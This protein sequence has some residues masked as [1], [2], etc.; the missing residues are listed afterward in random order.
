MPETN[1]LGSPS[2]SFKAPSPWSVLAVT[3]LVQVLISGGALTPPVFAPEAAADMGVEPRL[4]GF[5]T[6]IVYLGAML[7]S[8]PTGSIVH[9]YGAM[10][11]SQVCLA[12]VALGLAVL[13]ISEPLLAL[14]GALVIGLGYGP[15]T[16]ASTHM[17]ARST[18]A[19]H[20]GV[21]FSLKQTGVPLGGMLAG[22]LVPPLA[23][24]FGWQIAA[25]VTAGAAL[26]ALVVVQP[27]RAPLDTDRRPDFPVRLSTLLGPLAS[28]WRH[29]A[30]R[31]LALASF[32]FAAMQLSLST[33]LVVYLVEVAHQS[34]VTAGLLFSLTQAS[35]VV[36][37]VVWGAV[38]DRWLGGRL[39]LVVVAAAMA[40]S[41][42]A[43]AAFDAS[44]PVA[45]IAPVVG[46]FG[47]TAIG[48]NGVWI[49]E[50]SHHAPDGEAG[51][52]TG[53]ALFFT[54]G[55]VVFGPALFGL[56]AGLPG[57]YGLG[58]I[59]YAGLA[60]AGGALILGLPSRGDQKP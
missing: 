13:A 20:R 36:G 51:T 7:T 35:G 4:I 22:V 53:G 39:M 60:L 57:S 48:W 54:Y 9:R 58:F 30:L 27:W 44:W 24:T 3:T 8:V 16:P 10:R 26:L 46:L 42:G 12:L 6:S 14:V 56:I 47:A 28:V 11:T 18:P 31:R 15:V 40:A 41:A 38:A 23:L 29:R 49:A 34:L 2:S 52:A 1:K 33:F 25:L 50:V 21:I 43:A 55:G 45:M 37:R 17:L 32:T 59:V 5:Y 19:R